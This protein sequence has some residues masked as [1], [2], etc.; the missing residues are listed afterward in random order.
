MKT[1]LED[2][3]AVKKKLLVEIE[4]QE[5]DR[6][7][8]EAYGEIGKH[9]KI[10]GFRPGKVPRKILERSFGGQVV[11]DVTKDLI[12]ETFPKAIQDLDI[13]PV[14]VPL[15]EKDALKQ[16]QDFKYA[17]VMEVLPQIELKN[18]LGFEVEKGEYSVTEQDVLDRLEQI[19]KANGKL[20]PV[21]TGRPIQM[22]DYVVLDYE[23]FEGDLLLDD[24]K[25]TDFLLRVGS[26]DFHPRFEESLI[27]CNKGDETEIKVDFEDGYSPSELAGRCVNFRVRIIDIKKMELPDLNDS[28]AQGLGADFKDF[29]DLRHKVREAIT[30]QEEKRIDRELKQGLLEKILG[31]VDFEIPQALVES[32]IDY[33]VENIKQNLKRN[34]SSLEKAGLSEQEVRNDLKLASTRR[35]KERLALGQIGKQ[36]GI[37]VDEENLVEGFNELASATGQDPVALRRY[38]EAKN[39]VDSLREKLLE[40]K[41]LN[42]LVEH[43]KIIS[44]IGS[45]SEGNSK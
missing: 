44:R 37:V 14:G 18:Y 1:S 21:D 9:A 23:G 32:E 12:N 27:G 7:L 6:K 11:D 10:P 5:V 29:A 13:H 26:H 34:G 36:D 8:N 4:R 16:G 33:A 45:V 20:I 40:E 30:S 15:L 24:I 28:F 31:S 41:T 35:V 42:Y 3:S 19:R 43:A 39:L 38:Y 17:A 22:D 2:I 25:S